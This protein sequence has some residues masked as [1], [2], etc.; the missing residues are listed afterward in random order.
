MVGLEGGVLVLR[1]GAGVG[2]DRGDEGAAVEGRDEAEGLVE[3]GP[4]VRDEV[5]QRADEFE[6]RLP[7][8]GDGLLQRPA[9]LAHGREVV[10][11]A[12][13]GVGLRLHGRWRRGRRRGFWI[14]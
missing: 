12:G 3:G 13:G 11:A 7:A 4:Q 8:G 6:L 14:E 1:V 9:L 5:L 2:V 10:A